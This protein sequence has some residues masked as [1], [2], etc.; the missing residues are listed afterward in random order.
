MHYLGIVV[1]VAGFVVL[2]RWFWQ[3]T[4]F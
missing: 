2:A 4:G 1:G 3:G